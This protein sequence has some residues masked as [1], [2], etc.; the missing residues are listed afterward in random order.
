[1]AFTI[2]LHLLLVLFPLKYTANDN[3]GITV[4]LI[5]RNS[6]LSPFYNASVTHFDRLH[7]AFERSLKRVNNFKRV[8]ENRAR[9]S[10]FQT[11]IIPSEGEG[12]FLMNIS[13]GT[14][15]FQV[16]GIVDTGSD[17][18]WTQCLPCRECFK[19]KLPF[20]NPKHSSSYQTVSCESSACN[21]LY[22]STCSGDRKTC[23]FGY[24]YGDG[25]ETSGVLSSDTFTMGI[26]NPVSL[27][28]ISFGCAHDTTGKF[29]ES[30]SGLVGL[31]GGKISFISQIG[32]SVGRRFSYCNPRVEA[33]S[34]SS[35]VVSGIMSFG[36][37]AVVSGSGV[38][39]TPIISK[40]LDTFYYL[41]LKGISVGNKRVSY[42]GSKVTENENEGNIIIDSGTTLTFLPAGFFDDL[43]KAL[44]EAIDG[45]KVDDPG[46]VLRLCYKSTVDN[47]NIPILTAHFEGGDVELQ[48]FNTFVQV[49]DG[50]V[51]LSM[52][53]GDTPVYGNL[54]QRNFLIGYDLEASKVSLVSRDCSKH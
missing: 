15:P 6:P 14:P 21:H 30:M 1:M 54:A 28:N 9:S 34:T 40:E 7:D 53:E 11:Q 17:L 4:D 47:L 3:V 42:K 5:P 52:L 35:K 43:V 32:E 44:E 26:K 2:V 23:E 41:T 33:S 29:D 8:L 25:S 49:A 19:Q 39:T 51:C 45:E 36:K 48:P 50:V 37:D 31:G 18:T 13:I 16:L 24:S 20:F 46:N 38:V 12:E 10:K 27:R 22:L